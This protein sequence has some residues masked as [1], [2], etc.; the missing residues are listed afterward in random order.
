MSGKKEQ[1][2]VLKLST[3]PRTL[4]VR[5]LAGERSTDDFFRLVKVA[6]PAV[7]GLLL[8]GLKSVEKEATAAQAIMQLLAGAGSAGA[9]QLF[10]MFEPAE[11][12]FFR[13]EL[14]Y[15]SAWVEDA[16]HKRREIDQAVFDEVF[17][18]EIGAVLQALVFA[19]KVN[20]LSFQTAL[21]G[22]GIKPVAGAKPSDSEVSSTSV[23][24]SKG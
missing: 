14:L 18:G 21:A 8:G 24:P 11:M 17:Q 3:G 12:R 2:T 10:A 16:E 19:A 20:W 6:G 22:L 13:T 23:G 7:V 4:W 5:Q 1:S 15:G 9:G